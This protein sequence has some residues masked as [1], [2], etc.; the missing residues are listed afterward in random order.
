MI[1]QYEVILRINNKISILNV[2]LNNIFVQN[3]V[4][5]DLSSKIDFYYMHITLLN[6][7]HLGIST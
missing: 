6:L 7:T 4:M 2:Q 3:A 5:C 1:S